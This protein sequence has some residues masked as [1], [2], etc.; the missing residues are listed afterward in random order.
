MTEDI[1]TKVDNTIDLLDRKARELLDASKSE[2]TKRA[3]T[4]D[5]KSFLRWA[6]EQELVCLPAETET[7]VLYCTHLVELG[8]KPSTITRSLTAISQA[9]KSMGMD[10]PTLSPVVGE[11]LKGIRRTHG[12]EQKKARPLLLAE[13]K[14]VVARCGPSFLGRR[15]AALILVGWAGALRRSELVALNLDDIEFVKQ[16]M[17][18]KIKRS[19]TD[20]EGEGF[21]IGVPFA[22][23]EDICPVLALQ[24]WIKL[25]NIQD[26]PVFYSIGPTGKGRFHADVEN[27][28]HLSGKSVNLIIKRRVR[29]A[30][31]SPTDYSG[32]SL[33]AGFITSAAE[34]ETPEH[35]IQ[36]HTRHQSTRVLRGYIRQGDVFNNNPLSILL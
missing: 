3:Y 33:R 9:H 23:K 25:A 29:H 19:K 7:I 15:D 10:S 34:K 28:R 4:S 18:I 24:K 2:S 35:L 6:L 8:R 27:K 17:T 5:W 31:I 13:L 1:Q 16:G 32:H 12:A 20:Q 30:E 21:L 26:G 11:L 14:K 36:S 22:Q